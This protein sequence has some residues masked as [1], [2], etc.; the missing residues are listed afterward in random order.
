MWWY[1]E[2][3]QPCQL[4]DGWNAGKRMDENTGSE[5]VREESGDRLAST[6]LQGRPRIAPKVNFF[7]ALIYNFLINFHSQKRGNIISIIS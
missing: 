3:I 6:Y 1:R 4:S 2:V 5:G 7:L